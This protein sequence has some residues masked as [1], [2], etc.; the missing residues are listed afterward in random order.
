MFGSLSSSDHGCTGIGLEATSGR[1][2][3]FAPAFF[4]ADTTA[5][6]E[7]LPASTGKQ[8]TPPCR[9]SAAYHM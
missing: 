8:P 5:R 6:L 2:A 4:V 7:S 1:S 9:Y 3:R